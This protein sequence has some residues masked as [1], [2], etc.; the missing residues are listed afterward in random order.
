MNPE[1]LELFCQ[2]TN[3]GDVEVYGGYSPARVVRHRKL[4]YMGCYDLQGIQA[5]ASQLLYGKQAR[6]GTF[7]FYQC[8]VCG[9]E[10]AYVQR[11][12]MLSEVKKKS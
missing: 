8:P 5:I 11:G 2:N 10:R 7:Y 3:C 1:N 6:A 9:A 4:N 12:D